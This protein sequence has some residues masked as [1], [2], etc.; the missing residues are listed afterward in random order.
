MPSSPST[1]VAIPLPAE[2]LGLAAGATAPDDGWHSLLL[3]MG[4]WAVARADVALVVRDAAALLA[5][6]L[7][8]DASI[9]AELIDDQR[10]FQVALTPARQ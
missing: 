6:T 3:N 2:R 7:D 10:T 1:H 9:V 8:A 5:E 4:R